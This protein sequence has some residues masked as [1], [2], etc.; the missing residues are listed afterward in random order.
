MQYVSNIYK[1]Y[2]A[3]RLAVAEMEKKKE[4]DPLQLVRFDVAGNDLP[5]ACKVTPPFSSEL[6]PQLWVISRYRLILE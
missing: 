2:E 1:C 4:A 6:D 5:V 3:Y